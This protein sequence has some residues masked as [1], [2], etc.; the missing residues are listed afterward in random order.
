[1][2]TFIQWLEQ[3]Q[4]QGSGDPDFDKKMI[5][6]AKAPNGQAVMQKLIADK[7]QKSIATKDAKGIAL[8]TSLEKNA[9]QSNNSSAQQ[10]PGA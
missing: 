10:R 7:K 3:M 2:K 1:M 6:A 8:T 9:A 4:N 5:D